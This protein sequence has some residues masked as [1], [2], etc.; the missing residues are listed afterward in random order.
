MMASLHRYLII[1]TLLLAFLP[2]FGQGPA[3]SDTGIP[4]NYKPEF[5]RLRNHDLIDAEQKAILNSDG[6]ADGFFTPSD[7]DEVNRLLTSALIK[8]VD[9]LQYDIE[10]DTIF[11]HRLKVN[12]LK[13][14]E[15]IL[16]YYRQNWKPRSD[17]KVNPA[18]LPLILSAYEQCI[19]KDRANE[20]IEAIVDSLSYDAGT[21]LL[22]AGIFDKNPG[23][24][25]SKDL[26]LYKY[27]VLYPERIFPVLRENPE[28][29]FA[30]SLVKSV[31]KKNYGLRSLVHEV[32][33][34][35]IFQTK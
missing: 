14:L 16:R 17:K 6:K 26:L 5:N 2:S 28:L 21:T 29:P 32:V 11:D 19:K 34:S 13:G 23:Y 12:Y 4:A 27:C 24:Q 7:D 18:K 8:K 31:A 1:G 3:F 20:S 15:N 9:I 22:S 33:Q 10:T 25:H 30:E 35:R